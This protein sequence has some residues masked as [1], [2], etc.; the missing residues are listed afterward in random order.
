MPE[1]ITILGNSGLFHFTPFTKKSRLHNI[2]AESQNKRTPANI[3]K[4]VSKWIRLTPIID[5]KS[6]T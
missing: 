6:F 3:L 1:N 5:T 2:D 4:D